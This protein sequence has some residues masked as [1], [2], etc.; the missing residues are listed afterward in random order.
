MADEVAMLSR[1][2]GFSLSDISIPVRLW[3]GE[4]DRNCPVAM[5]RYLTRRSPRST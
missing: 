2:W 4:E 5:A 3:A 1:D